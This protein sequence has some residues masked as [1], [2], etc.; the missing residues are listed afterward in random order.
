ML[1]FV[2]STLQAVVY[3]PPFATRED[4]VTFAP[5]V[6][7][8]DISGG[9]YGYGYF[10]PSYN[11]AIGYSGKFTRLDLAAPGQPPDFANFQTELGQG[12]Y[13]GQL[14]VLDLS[15]IDPDLKGFQGGFA[16]EAPVKNN[17]M[18]NYGFLVPFF[19]G[20]FFGKLVRVDLDYFN[21][22]AD[23]IAHQDQSEIE[24]IFDLETGT[25][26]N[27]TRIQNIRAPAYYAGVF[28]NHTAEVF[29]NGNWMNKS[30]PKDHGR[31]WMDNAC[32]VDVID[33]TQIDP[34]L[35]GFMGGF[36]AKQYGYLVPFNDG[37][38]FSSK[39]VRFEI[40]EFRRDTVEVLDVA[41]AVNDK[42]V[43]GFNQGGVYKNKG[44]L[45]PYRHTAAPIEGQRKTFGA[46]SD[47]PV[48]QG[49]FENAMHGKI[50]R[51][52]L[53]TFH[54]ASVEVRFP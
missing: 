21:L 14:R 50:V 54:E 12:A 26:K 43:S 9:R 52:D 42:S 29:E 30:V 23:P 6:Q 32:G 17:T 28:G 13:E 1:T 33:L 16:V 44:Y 19:N 40:S 37:K 20:K 53:D 48:D 45:F 15:K 24:S 4:L 11:R 38:K 7:S 31:G 2:A 22:C 41:A 5:K 18:A 47:L 8:F 27:R 46:N 35:K 34:S 10:V 36:Q 39:V 25:W 3:A 49:Q 51:F